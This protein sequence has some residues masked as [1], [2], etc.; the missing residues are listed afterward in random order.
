MG[1]TDFLFISGTASIDK[2]GDIVYPGNVE[3]QTER[4]LENISALLDS[5]HFSKEDLSSFIVYLR[6]IADYGFIKPVIENYCKNLPAIYVKA[7]VCRPGWLIEIE[8]TAA[9]FTSN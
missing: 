3:K 8:A 2:N 1:N 7:P 5:A 9:K 6:D 4:T